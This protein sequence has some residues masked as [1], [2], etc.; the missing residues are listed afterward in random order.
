MKSGLITKTDASKWQ[1]IFM[2]FIL[3]T[4]IFMPSH[5]F[6]KL[7]LGILILLVIGFT[8]WVGYFHGLGIAAIQQINSIFKEIDKN[9]EEKN[10]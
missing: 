7:L 9:K 1:T 5:I 3:V 4:L 10:D 2:V 8:Y 6:Y